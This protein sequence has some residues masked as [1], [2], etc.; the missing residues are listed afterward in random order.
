[1]ARKPRMHFADGTWPEGLK[2]SREMLLENLELCRSLMERVK[3]AGKFLLSQARN[4]LEERLLSPHWRN[5]SS[6]TSY[7]RFP[8][9]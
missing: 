8:H 3:A 6:R 4:V 9:A 2:R 5:N 7:W 1:M